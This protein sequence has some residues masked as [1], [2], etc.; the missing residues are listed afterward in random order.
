MS[1]I[2]SHHPDWQPPFCPD[3]GCRFHNNLA[4]SWPFKKAGFY[5]RQAKPHRIQRYTCLHCH[6]YFSRQTFSAD[7]WL[8]RPDLLPKLLTKTVG[9]MANSQA[10]R[11]LG[12]CPATVDRQ[13]SRL[14]RHCILFH[15]LEMQHAAPPR[16][17]AIDGFE[18]FEFSQY[19]PFHHHLAVGLPSAFVLGFTDSPLRRKGRMTP[20]QKRRRRQLEQQFGRPDPKAVEKDVTLL[21]EDVLRGCQEV[22]VRSDDHHTYRRVLARL[23]CRV[24]HQVTSSKQRRDK[25]NPLW[26]INVLDAGIRHGSANHRRETLAWSKRRQ[27]SAERLAVFLV[28]RNYVQVRPVKGGESTPAMLRGMREEPVKVLELLSRR[29]FATKVE[30]AGRWKEYYW[31]EV[32]TPV[33]GINRRHRLKYAY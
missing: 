22:I 28:W 4:Q 33:I 2:E 12:C 3:P 17:I 8:K 15:R 9:A 19:Y 27:R 11:D 13:L 31:S 18:S 10:A 23:G 25:D 7:Y 5:F 1:H 30:L 29:L 6:R 26:E 14:G 21:F 32:V 16:E 20:S 24:D